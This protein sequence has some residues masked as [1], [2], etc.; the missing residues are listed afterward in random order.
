MHHKSTA[1][2]EFEAELNKLTKG[3]ELRHGLS[4]AVQIGS[5]LWIT[6]DETV[7]V[8]RL[9]LQEKNEDGHLVFTGHRQYP[10]HDYITLAEP[11]DPA[12]I[13]SCE[14]ADLEGLDYDGN[15]LW[16]VGSHSLKRGKVSRTATAE[17][18]LENLATVSTDGNRFLLARIPV[19]KDDEG[20]SLAQEAVR[21]GKKLTAAQLKGNTKTSSL[22]KWLKKD[23][24]LRGSFSMPGKDNGFDIEGLA[25]TGDRVFLGLRGPV[26]RGWAIILELT[27]KKDSKKNPA[28]L[29]IKNLRKHF[30]Q[31]D[32]LGIRDLVEQ[33]ND[34]LVLAGPTMGLDGPVTLFR[35]KGGAQPEVESFVHRDELEVVLDVPYGRQVDHAEGITLLSTNGDNQQDSLLVVYDSA[36]EERQQG[37]TGVKA[38][39]FLLK[40][41]ER[42]IN[43]GN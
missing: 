38:D 35:W 23:K 3:K 9:S 37:E 19:V 33:E 10:L 8:E 32:G 21:E 40:R 43:N 12:D 26:L 5:T 17:E 36:S 24:H 27:F 16:L 28:T 14:E 1:V 11:P 13:K 31:L 7:S 20:Y 30:L 18:N 4:V 15:Y 25:A 6:N 41:D 2:L 42:E 22:L 39:V 29:R 34:L